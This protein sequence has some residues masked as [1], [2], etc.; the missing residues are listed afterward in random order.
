MRP[1]SSNLASFVLLTV[2][3]VG[4]TQ[5]QQLIHGDISISTQRG[6]TKADPKSQTIIYFRDDQSIKVSSL[7]LSADSISWLS[8]DGEHKATVAI[9]QIAKILIRDSKKGAKQGFLIALPVLFATGMVVTASLGNDDPPETNSPVIMPQLNAEAETILGGALIGVL[10]S[11][12]IGFP[13]GA[14]RGHR[15]VYIFEPE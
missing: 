6:I 9:T 1:I 12:F 15:T 10:G 5:T 2:A 11:T 13:I 8:D 7:E 4:C 14:M 3:L